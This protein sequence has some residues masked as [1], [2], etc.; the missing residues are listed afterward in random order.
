MEFIYEC[1][2]FLPYDFCK[3]VIDKFEKN[4]H[5]HKH[6]LTLGGNSDMKKSTDLCMNI[7]N[8]ENERNKFKDYTFSAIKKYVQ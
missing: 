1:E 6:G 3:H 2:N 4:K 5:Q 8:W 7:L